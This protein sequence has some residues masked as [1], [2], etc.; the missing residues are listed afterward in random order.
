MQITAIN[1]AFNF[2]QTICIN[3]SHGLKYVKEPVKREDGTNTFLTTAY[4]KKGL[5]IA[6][7]ELAQNIIR[8]LAK[9]RKI[10][11][12]EAHR[13]LADLKLERK[14]LESLPGKEIFVQYK[15]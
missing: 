13:R 2:K 14:E 5:L 9:R 15:E 7:N 4:N 1:K 3:G 8:K 10:D 11:T 12:E 6:T